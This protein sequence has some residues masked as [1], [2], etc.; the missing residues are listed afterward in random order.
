MTRD[1]EVSIQVGQKLNDHNTHKSVGYQI[2]LRV[3]LGIAYV[4][5][6]DNAYE[7]KSDVAQKRR[8]QLGI[9]SLTDMI[10]PRR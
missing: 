8:K 9:I 10:I 5:L 1:N 6:I 2:S 3:G 4:S 7:I